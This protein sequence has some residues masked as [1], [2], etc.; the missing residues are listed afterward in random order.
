MVEPSF[1]Y[2]ISLYSISQIYICLIV[3]TNT[4]PFTLSALMHLKR[5]SIFALLFPTAPWTLPEFIRVVNTAPAIHDV[6]LRFYFISDSII[7]LALLDW[8]I[9]DQLRPNLTGKRPRVNLCVNSCT[10][11]TIVCPESILGDLAA[12]EELMDLVERG[13]VVLGSD[14]QSPF[15]GYGHFFS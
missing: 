5:I 4:I 15:H 1:L 13:L 7:S 14:G 9:L 6:V 12:N 8:S 10:M 11:G 3:F 2:V